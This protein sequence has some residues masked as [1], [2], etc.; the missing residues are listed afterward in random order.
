[1][2]NFGVL[3]HSGG[4]NE[5]FYGLLGGQFKDYRALLKYT[6]DPKIGK[7]QITIPRARINIFGRGKKLPR[8]RPFK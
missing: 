6:M 4:S 8:S 5:P 1:M 2:P 3:D 7:F